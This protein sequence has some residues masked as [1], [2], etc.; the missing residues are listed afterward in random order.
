MQGG[1]LTEYPLPG[2]QL[3][4]GLILA[5]HPQQASHWLGTVPILQG[6]TELSSYSLG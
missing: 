4:V 6:K 1:I 5:P 3:L 2:T